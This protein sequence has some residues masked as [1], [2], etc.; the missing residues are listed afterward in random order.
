MPVTFCYD[1]EFAAKTMQALW[2]RTEVMRI[3]AAN[4]ITNFLQA[5]C[6]VEFEHIP[7]H[8]GDPWN[9]LADR[10][11]DRVSSGRFKTPCLQ[12]PCAHWLDD[13]SGKFLWAFMYGLDEQ[14]K[15]Q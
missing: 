8:N 4:A 13:S 3:D 6:I 7:A 14:E 9:E 12:P 5:R 1:A 2:K 15:L 11:C 10:L